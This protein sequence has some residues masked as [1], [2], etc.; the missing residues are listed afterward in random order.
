MR[1]F[2]LIQG[3]AEWHA[4]RAQHWNASD[5]PAMM[6]CS[7]YESR[8]QLLHRLATGIAPDVDAGTQRRFDEGHRIEALARVLAEKIVDEDLYPVTGV[9]GR[10][11]ASFDG[12]TLDD[13][14][15]FEHKTL[16]DALRTA[17]PRGC[18]GAD[19]PMQYR[20]QMEHQC[21]VSG[22]KKVLFMA[23]KWNGDVLAEK[24]ECWYTPDLALRK[25]IIAGW[26]Q[27][28]AD[29]QAYTPQ[30]DATPTP[31]G[32]APETLPALHIEVAGMVTASNLEA[33]KQHAM[34]VFAGI[35][36]TLET[37]GD[38]ADAEKTVK[39]CADVEDRLK[40]AKEH[41]L[42]QT[43]SIDQLFKAIDDIGAE[44]RRV[45]LDLDKLVKAR[46]E[47]IRADIVATAALAFRHHVEGI[48]TRL[49]KAY[50]PAVPT[51][52]GGAI[53]NKRTVE[54]LKDAVATELA[55]AKIAA[56]EVGDR[57]DL[58]LQFLRNNAAEHHA[59]FP[60]APIIVLKASDDFQTLVKSRIA[61]HLAAE[62]KRQEADR[63]RIREEERAKAM[64]YTLATAPP[65]HQTQ[66]PEFRGQ[67]EFDHWR[68]G[69]TNSASV[70]SLP[71]KDFG[72]N[73]CSDSERMRLI[74]S[75]R[76]YIEPNNDAAEIFISCDKSK[77]VY[78]NSPE[79][80]R[81]ILDA[82]IKK[83]FPQPA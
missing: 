6:G 12:L 9:E 50:M 83:S 13:G 73:E 75:G 19:L 74:E 5:A 60:D 27:L 57:I 67:D 52:F 42:S 23:S 35:N 64:E 72:P 63:A 36:R 47:T 45:R 28:A 76:A 2:D 40:A 70:K 8:T 82:A 59:L 55:R 16:N 20:V 30:E 61:E 32:K 7:P 21:M 43:A 51:D 46:K 22:C 66:V 44:A 10:Y 15:A 41:A 56:T 77:G 25:E 81:K 78:C 1:I 24:R 37:D 29:L 34:A 26:E 54:S 39:W 58:N 53:K 69:G 3:S 62:E 71:V 48:N 17:M 14:I 79:E 33:Y 31:T 68:Q 18:T 49:G 4:H 80:L 38:F 11:S 65:N